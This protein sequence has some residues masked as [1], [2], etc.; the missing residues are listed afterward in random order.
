MKVQAVTAGRKSGIWQ[1]ATEVELRQLER[2]WDDYKVQSITHLPTNLQAFG[3]ETL[4]RGIC[5]CQ[6]DQM[7]SHYMQHMVIVD[8]VTIF[9]HSLNLAAVEQMSFAALTHSIWCNPIRPMFI[10]TVT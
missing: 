3:T 1:G 4:H 7:L 8:Y 5:C 9:M 6:L 2:Q 10:D